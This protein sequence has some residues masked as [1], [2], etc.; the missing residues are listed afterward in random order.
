LSLSSL[1]PPFGR[2]DEGR[3]RTIKGRSKANTTIAITEQPYRRKNYKE[4][5]YA[6]NLG[7]GNKKAAPFLKQ[8]FIG[9]IY[10]EYI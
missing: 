8:L 6:W 7:R 4:K 1:H 3:I 2:E 10:Y 5:T 9:P